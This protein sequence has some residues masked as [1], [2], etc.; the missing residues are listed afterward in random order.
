MSTRRKRIP[1]GDEDSDPDFEP[2]EGEDNDGYIEYEV[3]SPPPP[4][5]PPRDV[6]LL[7]LPPSPVSAPCRFSLEQDFQVM[8]DPRYLAFCVEF[9]TMV[10]ECVAMC[11]ANDNIDRTFSIVVEE[12]PDDEG[13][14]RLDKHLYMLAKYVPKEL[15]G[16]T[17]LPAEDTSVRENPHEKRT[18][19]MLRVSADVCMMRE[20]ARD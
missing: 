19:R 13:R 18:A 20:R 6:S 5:P 1:V 3:D 14:V 15:D 8:R 10:R 7:V 11:L 4:P 12:T 9:V 17:I 2:R 16:L